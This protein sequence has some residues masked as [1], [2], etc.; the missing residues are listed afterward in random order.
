MI[1]RAEGASACAHPALLA[2]RLHEQIESQIRQSIADGRISAGEQLPTETEL[3][4]RFKVSRSTIR[5]ALK[6]LEMAHLIMRIRG[7][8]TFVQGSNAAGVTG[9]SGA[10]AGVLVRSMPGG[11]GAL[12]TMPPIGVVL[13]FT[14]ESDALQTGI[15]LGVE[16]AAKSRGYTIMFA[17]TD[18]GD[19]TSED[20]A[21]SQLLKIGVCGL[22]V[23][24]ISNRASTSGVKKIIDRNVPLV[25]VDR[26][27]S[28]L[29]TSYVTSDNYAG[30]YRATEHLI[31]LGYQSFT[32]VHQPGGPA[33]LVTTS[34]RDRYQGF[35]Q[36]LR[37]YGLSDRVRPPASLDSDAPETLHQLIGASRPAAALPHAIVAVA[38]YQAIAVMRA[39]ATLGLKPPDDFALVGYD[40]VPIASQ[41]PVPLTTVIQPRYDQG[42]QAGHLLLDKIQGHPVRND[43]LVLTTTLVVRE[44]CGA[45]RVVRSRAEA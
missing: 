45:H 11:S 38:D 42:F 32:F 8:G 13:R 1:L 35:C 12:S 27:L 34:I 41:L 17:R 26:Y 36:A 19:E 5:Q 18:E 21:I 14:A 10:N 9:I 25:L 28:D 39:A 44:S 7:R 4:R 2:M 31:L 40:D 22:V 29:D 15:L 20:N 6:A 30:A 33:V 24:P 23:M 16:H 43:K 37:D 3:S